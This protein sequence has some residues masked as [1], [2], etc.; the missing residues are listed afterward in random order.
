VVLVAVVAMV[1]VVRAVARAACVNDHTY[2]ARTASVAS[3]A[4][5]WVAYFSPVPS[6]ARAVYVRDNEAARPILLIHIPKTGGESIATTLGIQS[7]G[8][9][10]PSSRLGAPIEPYEG[11]GTKE[12]ERIPHM[13][14][15]H[16][17]HDSA[18]T[19]KTFYTDEEWDHVYKIS[20]VRNPWHRAVS[21]WS[22]LTS[23]TGYSSTA[24]AG[25]CDCGLA[26]ST[27][28]TASVLQ[29]QG[30]DAKQVTT[31]EVDEGCEFCS[32][33]RSNYTD[34]TE[35]AY[36]VDPGV[37]ASVS[38]LQQENAMVDF[39]GRTEN[40]QQHFEMALVAAGNNATLAAACAAS[41]L[42]DTHGTDYGDYTNYLTS[43]F[44]LSYPAFVSDGAAF[45]YEF[46]GTD[47]TNVAFSTTARAEV[48]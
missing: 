4:L 43:E 48:H 42:H 26:R 15:L 20:F 8:E 32:W 16:E 17:I 10:V 41:L 46:N 34:S 27:A 36:L 5:V 40:L 13:D 25:P 18:Y 14:A 3:S 21:A 24:S 11:S 2:M 19:A 1:A 39:V 33:V 30:L 28:R 45:G 9:G 23:I 44:T 37:L 29:P 6:A 38:E 47:P 35:L 22:M 12:C 31:R 7:L